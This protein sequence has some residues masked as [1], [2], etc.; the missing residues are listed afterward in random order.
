MIELNSKNFPENTMFIFTRENIRGYVDSYSIAVRVKGENIL[1][2]LSTVSGT[3]SYA[4]DKISRVVGDE[5][6][7]DVLIKTASVIPLQR[8]GPIIDS[9]VRTSMDDLKERLRMQHTLQQPL[10]EIFERVE[11]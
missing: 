7:L 1:R 3:L 8:E 5:H 10:I 2:V 4:V 11:I 6:A 9:L